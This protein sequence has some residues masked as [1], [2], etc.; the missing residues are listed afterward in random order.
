MYSSTKIDASNFVSGVDKAFMITIGISLFFLVGITIL[1]IYFIIK[2]NH[3]KH[4]KAIQNTGN[5]K[6]EI[7]W[8]IIPTFLVMVMFYYGWAGWKPMRNPPK[9]AIQIDAIGRMWNFKFK[10]ENGRITDTLVVPQDK[11]VKLN[12]IALDVI[13]SLY[14]PAFRVKEDMVPGKKKYMWFVPKKLGT[15]NLFCAEYCGL[16]HSYMNSGVKVLP[17]KDFNTWLATADKSREAG[18]QEEEIPGSRGL[19]LLRKNG[20]VACHS[21]DGSKQIGP[22]YLGSYGEKIIVITGGNENEVVVDDD[23]IRK[24]IIDP[25]AD[26]V[27][28]YSK[29]LMTS[30]KDLLTEEEINEIIN[31]IKVLNGK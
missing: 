17:L 30:Y 2:Y 20:C 31:F 21:S 12:L 10:Y 11:A 22:T 6:L 13:H 18:T 8:T 27:K 26:V 1:M 14:I 23:Y 19:E 9:D 28:G 7:I 15:Y 25:N 3:K 29:G 4:P 24:S 5:T 16:N